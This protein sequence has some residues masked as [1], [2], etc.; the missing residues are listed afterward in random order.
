MDFDAWTLRSKTSP[1]RVAE[2]TRLFR[3]AS[4]ALSEAIRIEMVGEK[5][6]FCV[7]QITIAAIKD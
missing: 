4:P 7:P 2:L 1:E 3:G 5:I 6:G